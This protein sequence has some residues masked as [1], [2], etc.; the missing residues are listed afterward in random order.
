MSVEKVNTRAGECTDLIFETR[1]LENTG[2][3]G[4]VFGN[5]KKV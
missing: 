2:T 5:L 3:F 1:F 4:Y